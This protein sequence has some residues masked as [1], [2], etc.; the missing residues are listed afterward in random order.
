MVHE[1]TIGIEEDDVAK[2]TITRVTDD[3]GGTLVLRRIDKKTGLST[4]LADTSLR[5][6]R[7]KI[8]DSMSAL[9]DTG[10]EASPIFAPDD[11]PATPVV[12]PELSTAEKISFAAKY[13]VGKLH[14]ES[15]PDT[16][17]GNLACAW[18]VNFVIYSV[19]GRVVAADT[20]STSSLYGALLDGVG[21]AL[22]GAEPGC[23]VVSPGE[24]KD[25]LAVHGHVGIVDEGNLIYSNSSTKRGWAQNYNIE[26]WNERYGLM[27]HLHTTYFRV[28]SI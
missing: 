17:H 14:S 22:D 6:L 8:G 1:S 4:Y 27:M 13:Y 9:D 25:G 16:D 15:V 24:F 10:N 19:L 23:I 12:S 3:T 21:E 26:S 18:A 28:T 2:Y 7:S 5:F 20:L 11:A